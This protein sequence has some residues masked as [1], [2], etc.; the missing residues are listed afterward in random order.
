MNGL[1]QEWPLSI[2]LIVRHAE[3]LH[4]KKTL[5]T[6]VETG[7][8]VTPYAEAIARSRRLMAALGR[9]GVERDDRV[10]TFSWNH[11][12]HF[13]AYLAIPCMGAILHTLNIRL[14]DE[15]LAYIVEHAGDTVVLVD[16]C[17][18]PAWE[19]VAA[20][21][22]CVRHVIAVG[23]GATPPGAL[24]YEEMLA[25]SAPV[26]ELPELPESQAA[27]M[28]YTTGTTGR[29]K[30]V[31][32]SHRSNVLHAFATA[33]SDAFGLQER[34][35]ALPIVPLFHANGWGFPY[36][37]LLT[38]ADIVMPGPY[39]QPAELVALMV[40][41]RVTVAAGVP[42]IWQMLLEPMTKAKAGLTQLDR[43]LCGGSALPPSLQRAYF[44]ALGVRVLHAWGMTETSP[45][46]SLSR[47]LARH[48]L[49]DQDELGRVWSSQG[50][51]LPGV[52]IRLVGDEGRELA[53]DGQAVGEL[54]VRGNWIAA[55]YYNDDSSA[56]R[57]DDGWLR[58]GDVATIDA[59]GYIRIADRSKDL[60][61]S[62]GEWISSV[63]LEA[64]IMSHAQ[65]ADAA[66]IAVPH[67]TWDERPLAVVV[68]RAG[69]ALTKE[70][71]VEHLRPHVAKWWL[72]DDVVFLD[73]IPKTSVGKSDKKALRA[74]FKGHVLP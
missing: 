5:T 8:R 21:V 3:R 72:P 74:R 30:A 48:Q 40:E 64:L 62:G 29:P 71:V 28:C 42:S 49:L 56:A 12:E 23:V 25:A 6:R 26:A 37:C 11:Q 57:F 46:A 27:A 58:T 45:L 41:R 60:V 20:R 70:Q 39:L 32:Y 67:P 1:M 51:P 54:Q 59:D 16:K 38:G 4:A 65:V 34:D 22:D 69:A 68:A 9:L 52:E 14:F 33:M 47:P 73:Q 18:W 15:D 35:V 53:W 36:S 61:K 19:R 66:V 50:R 2:A 10:A 24:D 7:F 31:V 43:L 13:E 63:Q 17:L 55:A 44:E